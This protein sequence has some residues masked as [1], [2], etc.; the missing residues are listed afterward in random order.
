MELAERS[1]FSVYFSLNLI[2]PWACLSKLLYISINKKFLEKKPGSPHC[3]T[4]ETNP[5]RD[6][7]VEDSVPGLAQ[8]VKEP[9]LP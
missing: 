9:A 7:E 5:T 1:G 3:G 6:R 4:V 8:W 2:L